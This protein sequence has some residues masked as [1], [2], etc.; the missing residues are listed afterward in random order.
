MPCFVWYPDRKR[1]GTPREISYTD[2]F[3]LAD[4]EN[5][6]HIVVTTYFQSHD[7]HRKLHTFCGLV[8]I[9][10]LQR[11][12][13]GSLLTRVRDVPTCMKCIARAP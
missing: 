7:T 12:T 8:I 6:G 11:T 5:I 9:K 13:K 10:D 1:E 2:P 4:D 3:V